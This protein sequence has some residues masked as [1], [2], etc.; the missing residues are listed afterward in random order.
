M[1]SKSII[2][3]WG[4]VMRKYILKRIV[5][6]VVTLF[7]ILFVL[8]L[9]LH[10]MPGSPFNDEKLT[11]TQKELI[12]R[13]YGLDKPVLVQFGL[14]VKNMLRGD[15]GVSYNI[16]K[17]TP[18]SILLKSCLST[19]FLLGLKAVALGILIGVPLGIL[20]ALKKNKIP[21]ILSNFISVLGVS[22]P[23]YVFALAFS[24]FLAYK[25]KLFPLFY[26]ST[27]VFKSTLL[28]TFAL[29]IYVIAYMIRFTRNELLQVID[30]DY[31]LFSRTK[32]LSNMRIIM[33]HAMRNVVNSLITVLGPITVWLM[34]GSVVVERIFSI[35][36]IG[37]MLVT[38]IQTNDY[39]VVIALSFM[40][41]VLYIVVMLAVDI[42]YGIV[43][44]RI[45]VSKEVA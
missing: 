36:G 30:S 15:F 24:Y 2:W 40:Y 38:A 22:V 31:I 35:P 23:S 44:P 21:D 16:S 28:P 34:T 39:N 32:G 29:S 9:M 26:Q 45:R 14:Y 19:S 33:V 41:S 42:L 8:F 3:L 37:S 11:E 5:I 17:N 20:S 4:G 13:K 27:N 18:I 12:Y 1:S 7:I 43:D 10:M 6:S 25:A